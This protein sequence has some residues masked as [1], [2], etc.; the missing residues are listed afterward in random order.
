MDNERAVEVIKNYVGCYLGFLS[1]EEYEAMELAIDAL[2]EN[3]IRM[4][5]IEEWE[6]DFK[7]YVDGLSLSRD[8]YKG[9]REYIDEVPTVTEK[10]QGEWIDQDFDD[11]K[12][13][14]Y[15][16][17]QCGHYQDDITN[18]CPNCGAKMSNSV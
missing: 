8:D 18:F 14:D 7:K 3:V 16:C 4:N 2:E 6:N 5:T 10:P 17:N 13:S 9:I 15:R 11:L 1:G 12:I